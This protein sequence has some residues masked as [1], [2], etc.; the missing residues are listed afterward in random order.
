MTALEVEHW[1]NRADADSDLVALVLRLREA[2]FLGDD[3]LTDV[4][5]TVG[6]SA[7]AIN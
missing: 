7:S 4:G 5:K 3:D 6:K 2:G 1:F